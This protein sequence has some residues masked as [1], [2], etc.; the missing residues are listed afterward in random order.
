[1]SDASLRSSKQVGKAGWGI[2][3][4]VFLG[5]GVFIFASIAI[6]F[7][8]PVLQELQLGANMTAFLLTAGFGVV[9]AG[10]VTALVYAY[11]LRLPDIGL[12]RLKLG[13]VG[14]AL[15][16]V[17]AYFIASFTI[18]FL[19]GLVLPYDQ[20]QVQDVGFSNPGQLELVLVF[21]AL[22]VMAP[23][24]EELLFRGFMFRGLRRRLSFWPAALIVSLLF[25]LVHGQINV[26][27]D[28]FALSLVLC[29]LREHT[30]SL[31][32]CIILHA[33]KNL[34]AFVILF[35]IGAGGV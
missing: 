16:G 6:G 13:H 2:P 29:Y 27:L 35:I 23:I 20:Q 31:W 14:M 12:G 4:A 21:V 22:V 5:S 32:P 1:M 24:A 9:L 33:S 30:D 26:G 28:V 18:S 10:L 34:I 7:F 3:G 11:G 8:V 15:L 19:I 25:G 17:I